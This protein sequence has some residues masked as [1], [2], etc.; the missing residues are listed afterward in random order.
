MWAEI[1][2]AGGFV[3]LTGIVIKLQTDKI[4]KVEKNKVNKELC[5]ERSINMMATLTRIDKRVEKIAN[6]KGIE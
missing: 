1:A 3:T 6:D 4:N 5:D 2:A